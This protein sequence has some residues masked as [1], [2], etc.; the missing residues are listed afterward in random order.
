MT[1]R[2]KEVA[3]GHDVSHHPARAYRA[4]LAVAPEFEWDK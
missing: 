2:E 4:M 3:M 1:I